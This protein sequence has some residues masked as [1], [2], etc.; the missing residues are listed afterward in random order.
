MV[1]DSELL[2]PREV[3]PSYLQE[4][5]GSDL[6]VSAGWLFWVPT[7]IVL[8][9]PDSAIG[10]VRPWSWPCRTAVCVDCGTDA[11]QGGVLWYVWRLETTL[12]W[13]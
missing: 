4:R 12:L 3:I 6:E 8:T 7:D 1:S 13:C 9:F 2:F 11:H 10:G 5:L